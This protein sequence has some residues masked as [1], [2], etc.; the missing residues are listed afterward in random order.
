MTSQNNVCFEDTKE[1]NEIYVNREAT[2]SSDF[3]YLDYTLKQ[4][5]LTLYNENSD[6]V[7][8]IV[9]KYLLP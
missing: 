6:V 8:V 4:K 5:I 9:S 1:H 3:Q 2:I 7:N